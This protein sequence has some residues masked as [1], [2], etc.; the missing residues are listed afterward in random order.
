MKLTSHCLHA[1]AE[2]DADSLVDVVEQYGAQHDD[3]A[4]VYTAACVWIMFRYPPD[5]WDRRLR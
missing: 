3:P 1:S 2:T 5:E 4:C